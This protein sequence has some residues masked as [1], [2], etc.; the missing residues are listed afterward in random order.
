MDKDVFN[1]D[2]FG[3]W[4]SKCI[5]LDFGYPGIFNLA[6]LLLINIRRYLIWILENS[7]KFWDIQFGLKK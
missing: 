3:F 4:L 7:L 6:F 1:H 2:I 5:H